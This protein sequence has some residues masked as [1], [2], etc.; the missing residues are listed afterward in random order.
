VHSLP[1][2]PLLPLP[3]DNGAA[4]HRLRD[5]VELDC[6]HRLV[7]AGVSVRAYGALLLEV[8]RRS[9][10]RRLSTA[11][12]ARPSLLSRRIDLMTAIPSPTR[13]LRALLGTGLGAVLVA[14][15]C[16]APGPVAEVNGSAVLDESQVDAPPMR[17]SGPR[18]QYPPLL[19]DAGIE[20]QVI[21]EC[22]VDATGQVDSA[23]IVVVSST[24]KAFE[25]PAV[26]VVK[27]S[28]F[29]PAMLSG[30]PRAVRIRQPV[31]FHI[32]RRARAVTA[33]P[34]GTTRAETTL[35]FVRTTPPETTRV[36]VT[37]ASPRK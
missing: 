2:L 16:E 25:L 15:A 33:A 36:F 35:V 20:G 4:L 27:G 24:H 32:M 8:T 17:L 10:I 12:A 21:V 11:L 22:V 7:R 3:V 18:L 23:S 19:R 5:A 6:D 30:V 26:D 14:L 37:P 9:P 13:R 1:P 29:R 28:H 31:E 34:P